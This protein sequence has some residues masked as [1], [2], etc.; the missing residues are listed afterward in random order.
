MSTSGRKTILYTF[1]GGTDGANPQASLTAGSGGVPYG[2]TND[3]GSTTCNGGCGVVYELLSSGSGYTEKVLYRLLG[4]NDGIIPGNLYVDSS[5][6]P[7][8]TT[9]LGGGAAACYSASGG[10]GCGTVFKL[11][12]SGSGYAE[13]VLHSFQGGSDGIGPR[14]TLIADGSGAIYGT[15][16]YGGGASACSSPS[17]N[18]V[19]YGLQIDAVGIRL[20]R[21]HRSQLPRRKRRFHGRD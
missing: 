20:R 17:G 7:Y 18:P 8:G 14:G 15:T 6:A 3:G 11:T 12:P 1:Q 5:G 2:D 13:S 16:E 19:R 21:K 10:G 9:V 4:G